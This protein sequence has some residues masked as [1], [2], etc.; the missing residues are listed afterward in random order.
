MRVR[1]YF[2][3]QSCSKSN[4]GALL[5]D[6]HDNEGRCVHERERKGV[7]GFAIC[8]LSTG[9]GNLQ[10]Q[11]HAELFSRKPRRRTQSQRYLVSCGTAS[12]RS[13]A[14]GAHV[15]QANGL[16][17]GVRC[18]DSTSPGCG[19]AQARGTQSRDSTGAARSQGGVSHAQRP[20]VHTTETLVLGRTGAWA[21]ISA[22]D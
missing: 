19:F 10:I 8:R 9:R 21:S 11:T 3:S 18:A 15:T 17:I 1:A 4:F 7:L 2:F 12:R 22:H 6:V 13:T 16:A 20:S 5:G 14:I